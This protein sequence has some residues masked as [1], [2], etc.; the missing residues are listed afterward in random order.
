MP[1]E[2]RQL[3]YFLAVV[4][5]GSLTHASRRL[6]VAQP[7]LSQSIR[8]LERDVGAAVFHRAG[9]GVT[10][11]EAGRALVGPAQ[12]VLR[13]F[14]TAR[15][16]VQHVT[17]LTGGRLDIVAL[18]TLAVDPLAALVGRFRQLYPLVDVRIADPEQDT[19]VT[20]MVRDGESEL[21]LA[22]AP[23]RLEGLE[24]ITLSE[25][26]FFAVLPPQ[27]PQHSTPMPLAQLAAMPLIAAPEG[28]AM[29]ALID[30]ALT[31]DGHAP[32]IAIETAHRAAMVPLVLAGAG[33]TLL[34]KALA[35][36][37]GRRGAVFLLTEPRLV[38]T[39]RLV[40]RSQP[41]SPAASAF[42]RLADPARTQS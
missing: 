22:E 30:S 21:G 17:G 5:Y 38:R 11:T 25:Q 41:L 15:S 7:S 18:T 6:H 33:A 24:S 4:K 1:M 28:T 40:W 39:V 8:T 31:I 13:D 23:P 20:Q 14:A 12:Q 2:R 36:D 34:P 27:S 16:S 26:E 32:R 3:E 19:A 9:Y 35:E 42:L 10:L 37:A 29:R